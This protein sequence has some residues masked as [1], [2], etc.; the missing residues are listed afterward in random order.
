MGTLS[1]VSI[2]ADST[3]FNLDTING[4]SAPDDWAVYST[5][6]TPDQRRSGGGSLIGCT[7]YGGA[8]FSSATDARTVS[9]TNGTPTAS[10]SSSQCLFN[11]NFS[12][13]QGIT[14]TFPADTT[15]RTVWIVCGPYNTAPDTCQAVLSDGSAATIS[16]TMTG[17]GGSFNPWL[18]K[19]SYSA[20]SPGQTLTVNLFTQAGAPQTVTLQ[21]AAVAATGG[22]GGPTFPPPFR[23]NP[24][25]P[26]MVQ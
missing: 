9:W 14:L 3:A 7:F 26:I 5:T 12:A 13:G 11:S 22:G 10:G 1:F 16:S 25:I 2:G 20:N 19:I 4:G 17:A 18:I 8:T 6:T 23:P 24:M 21:A 15:V